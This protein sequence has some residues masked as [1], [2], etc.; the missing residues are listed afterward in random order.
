MLPRSIS[1]YISLQIIVLVTVVMLVF[2]AMINLVYD[3]GTDDSV[4][5]FMSMKAENYIQHK[6]PSESNASI[7][8]Y[9][10]YSSLP[11]T[12]QKIFEN[13]SWLEEELYYDY[14][15][16]RH[17]YLLPY[18]NPGT[19]QL[20]FVLHI[21]NESPDT[22]MP[23]LTIG[24]MTAML[25][26]VLA[27][28]SIGVIYNLGWSV[29]RPVKALREWNRQIA[30]KDLQ[31][32]NTQRRPDFRFDELNEVAGQIQSSLTEISQRNEKEKQLLRA[33]S[34]ELRTP[35]AIT[36]ASLELINKT[37]PQLTAKLSSKLSKIQRANTNMCATSETLLWLWSDDLAQFETQ[38]V[39]LG[40]VIKHELEHN[41][42]LAADKLLDISLF[43]QE[44]MIEANPVLVQILVRNLV[45]N[46][47]Q[48]SSEGKLLIDYQPDAGLTITNPV[49]VE[50]D[51]SNEFNDYGY[52]VGLYLV[53]T[54]CQK[55][56]WQCTISQETKQFKVQIGKFV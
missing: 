32:K 55:T 13:H 2:I 12:V 30:S 3:W 39:N 11:E 18:Y 28:L 48:Y 38:P 20:L 47:L 52:G 17:L 19:E 10:E 44:A 8:V 7:V 4:H 53:T 31:S 25:A 40:E 23:G 36:K 33:L 15:N 5:Y 1:R 37:E 41:R 45:R 46:A 6:R 50:T 24:G 49:A 56:G 27:V 43:E 54:L 29:L 34:H 9:P 35:L 16:G 51:H 14:Q 42:Y 22:A 26:L 21:Y